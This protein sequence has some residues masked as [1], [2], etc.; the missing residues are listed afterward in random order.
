MV[1]CNIRNT[2]FSNLCH[3]YFNGCI[4]MSSVRD[5][6]S[7]GRKLST[8]VSISSLLPVSFIKL[9]LSVEPYIYVME[10]SAAA[11]ICLHIA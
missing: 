7:S 5:M 10:Y 2:E 8:E 4:V 1:Y 9:T 11:V 6:S 3:V